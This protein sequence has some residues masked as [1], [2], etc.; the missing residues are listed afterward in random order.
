MLRV[1]DISPVVSIGHGFEMITMEVN[2][3]ITGFRSSFHILNVFK[4]SGSDITFLR[5]SNALRWFLFL[6]Y[7]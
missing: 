7:K 4:E 2:D 6:F 5:M 3:L 1:E